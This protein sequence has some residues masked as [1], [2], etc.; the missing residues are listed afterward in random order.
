[1]PGRRLGRLERRVRST[2]GVAVPVGAFSHA[3]VGE[4]KRSKPGPSWRR[5]LAR[6]QPMPR[7]GSAPRTS[8]G[9]LPEWSISRPATRSNRDS[10][11]REF[12]LKQGAFPRVG[13]AVHQSP[14]PHPLLLPTGWRRHPASRSAPVASI[15]R[16]RTGRRIVAEWEAWR[17][18]WIGHER[19]SQSRNQKRSPRPSCRCRSSRQ[20]GVPGYGR[21]FQ[22]WIWCCM[23]R[24]SNHLLRS[25]PGAWLSANHCA[26]LM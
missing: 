19:T 6:R 26:Q 24:R 2:G 20:P 7:G 21:G 3:R 9:L 23:C 5:E 4:R 14:E 18:G 17:G 11:S 16:R 15:V 22:R 8:C 1:M 13:R 25:T 12:D 10:P